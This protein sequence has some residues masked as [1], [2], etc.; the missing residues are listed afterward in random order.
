MSLGIESSIS[1]IDSSSLYR[2]LL[3]RHAQG[4]VKR[5]VKLKWRVLRVGSVLDCPYVGM[6][7]IKNRAEQ[8]LAEPTSP[9]RK[10]V[11]LRKVKLLYMFVLSF[12][13]WGDIPWNTVRIR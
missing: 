11:L 1:L 6:G 3:K 12:S 10:A 4:G 2:R 5:A 9:P 8:R 13:G 7:F